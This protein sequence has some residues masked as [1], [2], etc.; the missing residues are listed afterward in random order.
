VS[1]SL[2]SADKLTPF[3]SWRLLPET[4]QDA[5]LFEADYRFDQ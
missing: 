3:E 1:L 5:V 2:V 4:L